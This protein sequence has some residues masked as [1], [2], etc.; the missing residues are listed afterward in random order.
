M[1]TI[2]NP[3]HIDVRSVAVHSVR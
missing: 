1:S 2:F 3:R